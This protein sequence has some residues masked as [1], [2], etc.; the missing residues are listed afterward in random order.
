MNS[1]APKCAQSACSTSSW[2]GMADLVQ[3]T[4]EGGG[5][6]LAMTFVNHI[7]VARPVPDD[8]ATF[9]IHVRPRGDVRL[10]SEVRLAKGY[11]RLVETI[12]R[13]H[14]ELNKATI[15]GTTPWAPRL[16]GRRALAA[17]CIVMP[18]GPALKNGCVR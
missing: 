2:Q 5:V 12:R 16:V 4:I 9:K 6:Y 15:S 3:H 17:D 18:N 13:W 10:S 14:Q 7:F 1:K 11:G 8:G